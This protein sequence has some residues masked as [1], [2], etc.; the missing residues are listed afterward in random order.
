MRRIGELLPEVAAAL[1]IEAELRRARA[2][3]TWERTVGER[4]PAATGG[5]YLVE[6]REGD[7]LIV[8]GATQPIVAQELRL[9]SDELLEAFGRAMGGRNPDRLQVVVRARPPGD[10]IAPAPRPDVD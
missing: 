8:V 6:W 3:A 9:R 2:A 5:S 10:V 4:V 7:G 1:G